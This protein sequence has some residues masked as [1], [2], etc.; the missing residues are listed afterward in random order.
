[1]STLA[2][3]ATL[4]FKNL[5]FSSDSDR[6]LCEEKE[7]SRKITCKGRHLG[8]CI[9]VGEK[10]KEKIRFPCGVSAHSNNI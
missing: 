2:S 7:Y 4:F 5:P 10:E 9:C 3:T 1:M 8:V 6:A